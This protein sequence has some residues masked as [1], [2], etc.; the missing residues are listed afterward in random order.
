MQPLY[1]NSVGL[2]LGLL[3]G[4][5][6]LGWVVLV[7]LGWAKPLLDWVLSL[8]FLSFPYTM[9]PFSLITALSLVVF[10]FVCGYVM[11]WVLAAL[12]NFSRK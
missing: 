5:M 7:V 4:L 2:T 6:H 3:V 1:K 10:T 9:A 12:W 8:H 11:G